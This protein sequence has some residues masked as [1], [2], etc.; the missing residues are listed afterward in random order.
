M[1]SRHIYWVTLGSSTRAHPSRTTSWRLP[2]FKG[3]LREIFT[4]CHPLTTGGAHGPATHPATRF[5]RRATSPHRSRFL[6]SWYV[7]HHNQMRISIGIPRSSNFVGLS[8]LAKSHSPNNN[9][10]RIHKRNSPYS[11]SIRLAWN[12]HECP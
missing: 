4:P 9:Y 3:V 12:H 7:P 11:Y 1:R 8:N 6:C 10:F 2:T 5:S